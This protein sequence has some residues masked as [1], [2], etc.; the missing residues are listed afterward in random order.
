MNQSIEQESLVTDL[1]LSDVTRI[2]LKEDRLIDDLTTPNGQL[3]EILPNAIEE[4]K[5]WNPNF[6]RYSEDASSCWRS[7]DRNLLVP[8]N[9]RDPETI[10]CL[11]GY[12]REAYKRWGTQGIA[13]A[14]DEDISLQLGES[15]Q[16]YPF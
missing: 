15:F 1:R 7:C 3:R 10:E 9:W 6:N 14:G 13:L 5:R 2:Y 16:N 12:L 8:F 4:R 11:K